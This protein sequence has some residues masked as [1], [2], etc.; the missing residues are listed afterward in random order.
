MA[1]RRFNAGGKKHK[2][3]TEQQKQE[4]KEAFDLLDTDGS[5]DIDSK[6]SRAPCVTGTLQW[7]GDPRTPGGEDAST[8]LLPYVSKTVSISPSALK[9]IGA[10]VPQ[11]T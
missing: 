1:L 8:S 5:G 11:S 9:V 2:G 4:I 6:S 10:T 3:W 7:G